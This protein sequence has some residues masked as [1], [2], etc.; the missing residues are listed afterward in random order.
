MTNCTRCNKQKDFV[1]INT[2]VL[3]LVEYLK[4]KESNT[5]LCINCFM[6]K[7]L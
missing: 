1:I 6:E 3:S 5:V 4:Y 7:K 2:N